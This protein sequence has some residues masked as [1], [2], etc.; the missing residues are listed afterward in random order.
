MVFIV[1]YGSPRRPPPAGPSSCDRRLAAAYARVGKQQD[2]E[3]ERGVIARLAPF[4]D[5]ERFAAQFGT[6]VAR[7]DMLA[8]LKAAGFR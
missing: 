8:G 7:E 3:R 1:K 5:A 2:A 6:K 4:F